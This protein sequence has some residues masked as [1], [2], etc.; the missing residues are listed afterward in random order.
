[1]TVDGWPRSRFGRA[2]VA[3]IVGYAA[4]ALAAGWIIVAADPGED[5]TLEQDDVPLRLAALAND[6]S[7]VDHPV[8]AV[9]AAGAIHAGAGIGD[10]HADDDPAAAARG[11]RSVAAFAPAALSA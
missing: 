11:A 3:C 10:G 7:P 2:H 8:A 5:V 1:M 9:A 6:G 4:T